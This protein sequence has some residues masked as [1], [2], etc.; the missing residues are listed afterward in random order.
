MA[1]ANFPII[2]RAM[3]SAWMSCGKRFNG[4]KE[5]SSWTERN[6]KIFP[7]LSHVSQNK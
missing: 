1:M 5:V 4:G 6:R 7:S 3:A 2:L